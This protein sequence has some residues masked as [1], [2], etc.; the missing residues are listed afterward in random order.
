[1]KNLGC[2]IADVFGKHDLKKI[3][4]GVFCD[5]SVLKQLSESCPTS[6]HLVSIL[7]FVFILL[8]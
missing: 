8:L 2:R 5:G 1:V 7:I 4:D 3:P 6:K